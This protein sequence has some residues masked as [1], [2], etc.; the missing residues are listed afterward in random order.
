MKVRIEGAGHCV[1]ID[2]SALNY[3]LPEVAELA[4]DIWQRTRVD[5]PKTEIGFGG[6][7]VERTGD[8]PIPGNGA[9]EYKPDPVTA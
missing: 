7:I 8:R 3:T 2:G 4:E 1:E 9:Y 6:Q 5:L